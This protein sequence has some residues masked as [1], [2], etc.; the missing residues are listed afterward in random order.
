VIPDVGRKTHEIAPKNIPMALF[1]ESLVQLARYEKRER[2]RGILD[3]IK[4]RERPIIK[5]NNSKNSFKRIGISSNETIEIKPRN[6][7]A[8]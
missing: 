6:Q 4:S 3:R 7:L 5:S 8:H 1:F 2:E